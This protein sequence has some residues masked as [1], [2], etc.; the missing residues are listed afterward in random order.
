[1]ADVVPPI[2]VGATATV[3]PLAVHQSIVSK[4]LAEIRV[5]D[6]QVETLYNAHTVGLALFA[7]FI[8][9]VILGLIL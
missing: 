9:G 8:V 4:L 2:Q 1:M 6:V 3:V 5:L 7:G